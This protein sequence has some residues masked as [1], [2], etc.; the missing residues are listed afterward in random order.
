MSKAKVKYYI[1]ITLAISLGLSVI[2]YFKYFKY[3][4]NYDELESTF[5]V[6]N[7][8][9]IFIDSY[10]KSSNLA[11]FIINSISDLL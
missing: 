4:I 1:L 5:P 8:W 2:K 10:L 9:N 11:Y 7:E 3:E 6:S